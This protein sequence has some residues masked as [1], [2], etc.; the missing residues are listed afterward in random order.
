MCGSGRVGSAQKVRNSVGTPTVSSVN[1]DLR[2][3]V[4]EAEPEHGHGEDHDALGGHPCQ[5]DV[6]RN[7][8]AVDDA[9][10]LALGGLQRG[11]RIIDQHDVGDVAGHRAAAA[12]RDAHVRG[13]EPRASLT[14]SP[15]MAT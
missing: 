13:L 1:P 6:H 15:I 2:R 11:E 9:P 12:H 7:G 14:P 5:E 3:G 8:D 10:A 4:G